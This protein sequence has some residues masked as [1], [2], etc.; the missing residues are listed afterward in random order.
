MEPEWDTLR[1][2]PT[3]PRKLC[4]LKNGVGES[5]ASI[6][7]WVKKAFNVHNLWVEITLK[8]G[9]VSVW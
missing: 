1:E 3:Q 5:T 9:H 4:G 2:P 7:Y 8:T 6:S